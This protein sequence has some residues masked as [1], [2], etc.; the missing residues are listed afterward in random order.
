MKKI[1]HF[2]CTA[3]LFFVTFSSEIHANAG[4]LAETGCTS[5][6]FTNFDIGVSF[7]YLQCPEWG[8]AYI[9]EY[10]K[11]IY[12]YTPKAPI[13]VPTIQKLFQL[14]PRH[15]NESSIE[16]IKRIA[17]KKMSK[18]EQEICIITRANTYLNGREYYVIDDKNKFTENTTIHCSA[19]RV[20][21]EEGYYFMPNKTQ[22]YH[23]GKEDTAFYSISP[24]SI[25][26]LY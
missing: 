8:E 4:K 19:A 15:K 22:F 5:K 1:T 18:D 17:F 7:H 11:G 13:Y 16:A 3:M 25:E 20:H 21:L 14:Y 9:L 26:L 6:D 12:V 2:I 10:N 24:E 23:I